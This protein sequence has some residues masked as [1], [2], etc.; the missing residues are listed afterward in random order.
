MDYMCPL[1]VEG[2]R[3]GILKTSGH[4]SNYCFDINLPSLK[5]PEHWVKRGVALLLQTSS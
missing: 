3:K 1:Y 2:A 4:S 5:R